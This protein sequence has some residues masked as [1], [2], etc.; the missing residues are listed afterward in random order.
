MTA[1]IRSAVLPEYGREDYRDAVAVAIAIHQRTGANIVL[2]TDPA[3]P[4]YYGLD[5]RGDAPCFPF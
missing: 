5:L 3:A 4:G 2:D 1:D